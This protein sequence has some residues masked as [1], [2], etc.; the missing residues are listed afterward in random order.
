VPIGNGHAEMILE[1]FAHYDPVRVVPA[2][3]KGVLAGRPFVLYGF[4]RAKNCFDHCFDH[5][6][7]PIVEEKNRNRAGEP[8]G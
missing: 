7:S 6:E 4:K 5:F 1:G 3:G 2:V 8:L